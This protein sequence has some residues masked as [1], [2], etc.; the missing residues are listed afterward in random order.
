MR[1]NPL[2]AHHPTK[3]IDP[4][5]PSS[6]DSREIRFFIRDRGCEAVPLLAASHTMGSASA[7]GILLHLILLGMVFRCGAPSWVSHVGMPFIRTREAGLQVLLRL[8]GGCDT[9][10][11]SN[12]V[13][14]DKKSRK[15]RQ[16][17]IVEHQQQQA[18]EN[19][20]RRAAKL[21]WANPAAAAALT[22]EDL[23][24]YAEP[25]AA[26]EAKFRHLWEDGVLGEEQPQLSQLQLDALREII[27]VPLVRE[28]RSSRTPRSVEFEGAEG[29]RERGGWSSHGNQQEGLDA[30]VDGMMR[31][32]QADLDRPR[33]LTEDLGSVAEELGAR[34]R[35]DQD[36]AKIRSRV[37][38]SFVELSDL[39][40]S[41]ASN[42]GP[43][44][45]CGEPLGWDNVDSMEGMDEQEAVRAQQWSIEQP[46]VTPL[47]PRA[48]HH[49]ANQ[50]ERQEVIKAARGEACVVEVSSSDQDVI[51]ALQRSMSDA[52]SGTAGAVPHFGLKFRRGLFTY[53]SA[54]RGH[55]SSRVITKV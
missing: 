23:D 43:K 54:I 50:E 30:L 18:R 36:P 49:E 24:P 38:E 4:P 47:E 26:T 41:S 29:A 55:N 19:R 46:S 48:I 11:G 3:W 7:L 31:K 9:F 53:K 13:A 44:Y 34:R 27:A 25:T 22:P 45:G 37:E 1:L 5:S 21:G 15:A 42:G 12:A 33:G 40:F 8:R 10:E 39:Q 35:K 51:H 17:R 20:V 6:R 14:S 28:R 52:S 16:K 2:V 32:V